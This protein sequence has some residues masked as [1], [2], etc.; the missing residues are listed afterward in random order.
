MK[1]QTH[2]AELLKKKRKPANQM[3]H[4]RES[5]PGRRNIR[6]YEEQHEAQLGKHGFSSA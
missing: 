4:G 3:S 2:S 5:C 6:D 1:K